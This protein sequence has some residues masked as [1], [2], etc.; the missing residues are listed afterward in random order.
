MAVLSRAGG[1]GLVAGGHGP[2]ARH[3]VEAGP[4]R[5]RAHA[6]GEGRGELGSTLCSERRCVSTDQPRAQPMRRRPRALPRRAVQAYA[7]ACVRTAVSMTPFEL[8]MVTSTLAAWRPAPAAPAGTT[9]ALAWPPAGLLQA[10]AGATLAALPAQRPGELTAL[11]LRLAQAGWAPGARQAALLHA[12]VDAQLRAPRAGP[13]PIAGGGG[14]D[15]GWTA[16]YLSV[17]LAAWA[18][19]ALAGEE[20]EGE[21]EVALA[22]ALPSRQL[23]LRVL[24]RLQVRGDA[25]ERGRRSSPRALVHSAQP[26]VHCLPCVLVHVVCVLRRSF[27]RPWL[28]LALAHR[29]PPRLCTSSSTRRRRRCAAPSTR[30]LAWWPRRPRPLPAA[31]RKRSCWRRA[32][33]CTRRCAGCSG[34]PPRPSSLRRSGS[35]TRSRSCRC[36]RAVW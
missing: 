14:G 20:Q 12:H 8:L 9:K 24:Q 17:L 31:R 11:L 10:L 5:R 7:S 16:R 3:A 6:E 32:T 15:S 19:L 21:E 34:R 18:R 25:R 36:V 13:G 35:S 22:A 1:G 23:L 4:W 29:R 33:R 2:D 30:C 26:G 27:R 28:A